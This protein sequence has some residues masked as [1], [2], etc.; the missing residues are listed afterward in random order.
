MLPGALTRSLTLPTL[1][2]SDS[3]KHQPMA[4][5]AVGELPTRRLRNRRHRMCIVWLLLQEQESENH[6]KKLRF[7]PRRGGLYGDCGRQCLRGR[8]E[9]RPAGQRL[10]H[11]H[12]GEG[13]AGEG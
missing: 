5:S 13:G 11:H 10:L 6:E 2:S 12:Q 3:L 8:C 9:K 1:A 7:V 4:S